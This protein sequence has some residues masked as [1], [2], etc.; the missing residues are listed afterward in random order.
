MRLVDEDD[1]A[2]DPRAHALELRRNPQPM[3]PVTLGLCSQIELDMEVNRAAKDAPIRPEELEPDAAAGR[4]HDGSRA[5]L[6]RGRVRRA[7]ARCA[8]R[9][10]RR[11][12]RRERVRRQ[13][14]G[15][16]SR[17]NEPKSRVSTCIQ[18]PRAIAG[19][20][21]WEGEGG[22]GA[23]PGESPCPGRAVVALSRQA[24]HRLEFN[25]I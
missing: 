24:T 5:A 3:D 15:A 6:D 22:A 23:K 16:S 10:K 18:N 25:G 1:V 11:N 7:E 21:L 13:N 12:R 17:A 20:C 14:L 9:G 4:S 8:A 19:F 2:G